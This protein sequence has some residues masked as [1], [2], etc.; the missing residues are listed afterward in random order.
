MN[1]FKKFMFLLAFTMV[2]EKV[3]PA[4]FSFNSVYRC[5]N[6]EVIC[7]VGQGYSANPYCKF[8]EIKEETEEK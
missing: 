8:K 4:G 6:E 1:I 5:E 3:I 7:Y 2:C